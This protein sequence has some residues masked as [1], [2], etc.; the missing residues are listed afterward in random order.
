MFGSRFLD[1]FSTDSEKVYSFGNYDSSASLSLMQPNRYF[2]SLTKKMGLSGPT[3]VYVLHKWLILF[4]S[5]ATKAGSL[6]M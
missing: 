5:E 4:F 2:Y 1:I 3:V 6:K